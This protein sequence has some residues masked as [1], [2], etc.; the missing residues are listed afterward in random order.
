MKNKY[1]V[2]VFISAEMKVTHGM[3]TA[4]MYQLAQLHVKV[5]MFQAPNHSPVNL[6]VYI[7]PPPWELFVPLE[8][9]SGEV[10]LIKHLQ[11]SALYKCSFCFQTLKQWIHLQITSK[12]TRR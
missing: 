7:H 2:E 10:N 9:C 6:T 8:N 1:I 4:Y 3:D 11:D 5:A 12:F